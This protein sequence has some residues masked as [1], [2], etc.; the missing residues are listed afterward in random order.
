MPSRCWCCADPK[1]ET[2]VHLFFTSKAALTVWKYFLTRAGIAME[3]LSLHQAITKCWTAQ[4]LPRIKPIMQALPSCVVWEL[5][6]RRNNLKY[7]EA[8]SVIR[9]IYQV[10]TTIQALVQVRKPGLCV[11]HKWRDLLNM[12]QNYTPKFNFEKVILE[13]PLEGWIKVNTDGA[14]RGNP[15]RSSIGFCLRDDDGDLKYAT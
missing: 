15:G 7:G 8:V 5:W 1:E 10:S 9:V 6:K 13:F 4:L 11:P 12:L 3:G 2:L 14:Y